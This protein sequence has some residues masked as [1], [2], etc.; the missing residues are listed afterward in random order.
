MVPYTYYRP[1][2]SERDADGKS[3]KHTVLGLGELL[4]FPT[5]DAETRTGGAADRADMPGGVCRMSHR[6]GPIRGGS[7][8]LRQVARR[9]AGS[10]REAGQAGRRGTQARRGGQGGTCKSKIEDVAARDGA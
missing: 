6:A 10:E 7:R 5:S 1:C 9:E 8:V 2:E 3:R 4:E